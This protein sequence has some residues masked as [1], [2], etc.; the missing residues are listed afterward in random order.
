MRR[1]ERR[2]KV[3]KLFLFGAGAS[4]SLTKRGNSHTIWQAPLDCE[5]CE[6]IIKTKDKHKWVSEAI[7]RVGKD[8]RDH[9]EFEKLGLE[10][11]IIKQIGHF[12]FLDS[13]HP[14]RGNRRVINDYIN[15][16]IHLIAIVLSKTKSEKI[17]EIRTFLNDIFPTPYKYKIQKN[18]IITFNYDT[19]V[20]E[21]LLKRF[22]RTELY[23]D[24]IRTEKTNSSR[25]RP[26]GKKEYPLLVKLHG[27]INWRIRRQDLNN[28]LDS[29][30]PE[31]NKSNTNTYNTK[32]CYFIN[33]ITES[34]SVPSPEDDE[35]PCIIPPLP[36]K[37]ITNISIFRYLWTYAYEYLHECK[38]LIICGY[39]LPDTDTLAVSMFSNF[40]NKNLE[41]I[42]IID[43]NPMVIKKWKDLFT[44]KQINEKLRWE[45]YD[46]LSEY[47]RLNAK[48][49]PDRKRKRR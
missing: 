13:I 37:P 21:Y 46:D 38:E 40:S 17:D 4:Y 48:R 47:I 18:R 45:Y 42:T 41:K 27:S 44:R 25:R 16:L 15:D 22:K 32:G 14:R 30:I 9:H 24:Q 11:A 6:R 28:I 34:D 5:F 12:D 39:S 29:N 23:F 7:E 1:K 3:N 31:E 19:I 2:L 36:Q 43:P 49:N 26:D 8:W 20:E 35:A 10:E 33:T